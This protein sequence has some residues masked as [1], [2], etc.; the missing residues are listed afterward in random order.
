M[1]MD[2]VTRAQLEVISDVATMQVWRVLLADRGRNMEGLK[3]SRIQSR[4]SDTSGGVAW[5]LRELQRVDLAERIGVDGRSVLSQRWRATD[6][7][8]EWGGVDAADELL[9]RM[10]ER[11]VQSWREWV[12]RSWLIRKHEGSMARW[13]DV[14][15]NRDSRLHL[16]V[17][18]LLELDGEVQQLLTKWKQVDPGPGAEE[19]V[20]LVSGHPDPVA[21]D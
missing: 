2:P 4:L 5:H 18:Q 3:G 19:I 9:V 6:V 21:A 7:A 16:S 15:V 10:V 11:S 14:E 17:E 8:L 1:A 12:T 20:F 13:V